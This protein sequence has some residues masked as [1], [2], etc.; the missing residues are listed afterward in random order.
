[1][2]A[3]LRTVEHTKTDQELAI[4]IK[5]A[6]NSD[7]ISPK[8]KHVR[9]C[10]VYTWDHKSSQAFWTGIKVQVPRLLCL[11]TKQLL[12]RPLISGSLF[13]PTR[14]RLSKLS[15]PSTKCCRKAT[16]LPCERPWPIEVGS[17]V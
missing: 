6:T 17:I 8:R 5:K 13:L 16:R 7:E 1:M 10:I 14:S 15:S 9:A 2:S 11:Y 12:T 4:N 3:G